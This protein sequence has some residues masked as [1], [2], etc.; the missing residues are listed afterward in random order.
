MADGFVLVCGAQEFQDG[1]AVADGCAVGVGQDRADLVGGAAG[2]ALVFCV[3]LPGAV[4]AEVGVKGQ[5][6]LDAGEEVLAAWGDVE[7]A[8]ACEVGCGVFGHP[9]VAAGQHL[10][11]EGAVQASRALP[12]RVSFGHGSRVAWGRGGE[13]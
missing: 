10:V 3:H 2:P 12:D 5:A 6:A 8:A 1:E 11:R 9:Q 7:Y 13:G 4:H